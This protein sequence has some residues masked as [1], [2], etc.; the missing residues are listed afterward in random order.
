MKNKLLLAGVMTTVTLFSA[1][2][3]TFA[4]EDWKTV[5]GSDDGKSAISGA[6]VKLKPAE[7]P[8]EPTDSIEP[9]KPG[10]E[11][12]NVGPLTIDN[13]TPLDFGEHEVTEGIQVYSAQNE[14]S[15]HSSFR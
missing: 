12:G 9:S 15:F 14:D 7:N 6:H 13:V 4:A 10:G 3:L 1:S 8:T 5:M 11:T 2:M